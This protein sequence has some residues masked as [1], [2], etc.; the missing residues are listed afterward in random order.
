[1]RRVQRE[2]RQFTERKRA[3]HRRMQRVSCRRAINLSGPRLRH[4]DPTP[5]LGSR[6]DISRESSRRSRVF[7][8]RI[9]LLR[10]AARA[11]RLPRLMHRERDRRE[12]LRGMH[13]DRVSEKCIKL[14]RQTNDLILCAPTNVV[15]PVG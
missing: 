13:R 12:C 2:N 9:P 6:A 8:D 14:S 15:F 7:L 3:L 11:C 5:W 4:F 10:L 1:M